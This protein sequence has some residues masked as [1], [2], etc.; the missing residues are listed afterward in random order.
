MDQN[1]RRALPTAMRNLSGPLATLATTLWGFSA[2]WA[3]IIGA[4]AGLLA[5]YHELAEN[6][7]TELLEY[8]DAHKEEFSNDI[9]QSPEFKATFLNVWEISQTI[10]ILKSTILLS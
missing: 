6:R 4:G 9:I 5:V 3:V 7:L 10:F 8:I 1:L 2:V